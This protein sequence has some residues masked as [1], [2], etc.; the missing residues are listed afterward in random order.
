MTQFLQ[1]I[2]SKKKR[3]GGTPIE[4]KKRDLKDIS[5]NFHVQC[6]MKQ[7]GKCEIDKIVDFK[8]LFIF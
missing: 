2:N 7:L 6:F 4:I 3:E 1:H 5:I 8:E